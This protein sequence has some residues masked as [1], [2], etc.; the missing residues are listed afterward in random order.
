MSLPS[1]ILLG[2]PL[3]TFRESSIPGW[4]WDAC[5]DGVTCS[6]DSV[7]D[8]DNEFS[9]NNYAWSVTDGDCVKTPTTDVVGACNASATDG[10]NS[11]QAITKKHL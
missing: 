10:E 7:T 11:I 9:I 2:Q 6:E 4:F 3:M 8:A 1:V 5:C